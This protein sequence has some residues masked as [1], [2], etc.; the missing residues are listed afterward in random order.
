MNE[1]APKTCPKCGEENT[2][3]SNFCNNCGWDLKNPKRPLPGTLVFVLAA[4][5]LFFLLILLCGVGGYMFYSSGIPAEKAVPPIAGTPTPAPIA[6]DMP[7]VVAD[8][9]GLIHKPVADVERA[10]GK[11]LQTTKSGDEKNPVD[12]RL[13]VPTGAG[14]TVEVRF[15]R[16]KAVQIVIT[17]PRERSVKEPEELARL[18]G[19]ALSKADAKT[20]RIRNSYDWQSVA[21][22][23]AVFEYV[24][25]MRFNDSDFY[26]L[27]AKA[28]PE[29]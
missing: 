5:G 4:V 17:I 23:G 20:N 2:T 27:E 13:Y 22:R 19:F 18:G 25:A 9:P 3:F 26:R 15:E 6:P 1:I 8:I 12:V 28:A 29:K 24:Y 7:T 11:P 14:E 16:E 10:M 21:A